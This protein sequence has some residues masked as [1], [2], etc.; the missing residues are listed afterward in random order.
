MFLCI[1][2]KFADIVAS[3]DARLH[4]N[5][6]YQGKLGDPTESG[7]ESYRDDIKNTHISEIARSKR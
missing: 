6:V 3:D 4:T 2:K 5:Y 7:S 1:L